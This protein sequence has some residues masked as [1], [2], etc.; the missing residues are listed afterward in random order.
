LEKVLEEA[1]GTAA[2]PNW[3]DIKKQHS[4][5]RADRREEEKIS[6]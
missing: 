2:G 4:R 3:I 5:V 1:E 6:S